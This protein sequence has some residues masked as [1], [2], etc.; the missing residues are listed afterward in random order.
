MEE[1]MQESYF[2]Q[3]DGIDLGLRHRYH[4][5]VVYHF[6]SEVFDLL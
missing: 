2:E 3:S 6:L 5:F 1:F 4:R